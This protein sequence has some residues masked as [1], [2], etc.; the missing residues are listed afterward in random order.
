MQGIIFRK[1]E[2]LVREQILPARQLKHPVLIDTLPFFYEK[3]IESVSSKYERTSAV[4]GNT[5]A[6]EHGSERARLTSYDHSALINEYQLLRSAIFQVLHDGKVS[7]DYQET[8][9]I[10]AS[11]DSEIREAV[12]AFSL[13]QSG[14]RERFAAALMHDLR[15]PLSTNINALELILLTNDLTTIKIAAVK[16]ISGWK[17]ID[18][19]IMNYWI[20]W[21][22]MAE[23][24]C[25]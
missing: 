22:S 3:I 5:M 4:D 20:R 24:T 8:H 21:L 11:I 15:T 25:N 12:D 13:V 16:A 10:H 2:D 6:S 17:R 23:K 9:A 14:F 7:L 1:C 19:M 18:D